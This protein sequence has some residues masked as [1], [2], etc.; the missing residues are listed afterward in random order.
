MEN[1][2]SIIF[3]WWLM[4]AISILMLVSLLAAVILIRKR[5]RQGVGKLSWIKICLAVGMACFIPVM[6]I[7]GYVMYLRFA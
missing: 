3:F 7:V 5:C 6:L 1:A 4:I 2:P